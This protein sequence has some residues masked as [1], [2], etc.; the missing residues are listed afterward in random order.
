LPFGLIKNDENQKDSAALGGIFL[1]AA[2]SPPIAH[3]EQYFRQCFTVQEAQCRMMTADAAAGWENSNTIED[4]SRW[5]SLGS[6]SWHVC[7]KCLRSSV[8]QTK[9]K[10]SQV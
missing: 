5:R 9:N 7:W 4:A 6:A 10:H 1:T 8:D 3:A 2:C